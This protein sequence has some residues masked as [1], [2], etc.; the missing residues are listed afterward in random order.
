MIRL[1]AATAAL[2]LL[3]ACGDGQ[4]FEFGDP[5]GG[6]GT[7]EPPAAGTE[8]PTELAQ[9]LFAIT[10]N[11]DGAGGAGTL[12]VDLRSLD[13]SAFNAAYVR[14][15]SR[16]IDGYRAFEYREDANGNNRKFLAFV[17]ES[18]NGT[19]MAAAVA[20]GGQ[21]N[22]YFGGGFYAQN[23]AYSEPTGSAVPNSGVVRYSGS[24]A[25]II[26]IDTTG[27]VDYEGNNPPPS[28]NYPY[29]SSAVR[30]EALIIADFTNNTV[31][32]GIINR[33]IISE[34]GVT[35]LPESLDLVDLALTV[36]AI[37][38]NGEF[39][40]DVEPSGGTSSGST[41]GF[42]GG[43]FGGIGATDVAGVIL[44]NP[45]PSNSD[46]WE[47]GIF[48]FQTCTDVTCPEPNP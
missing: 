39:F 21:F 47:H 14:D 6:G 36:T 8:I 13:A 26:T 3:T 43:T 16:D 37:E 27:A 29:Q 35:V 11:P 44:I 42:Y 15:P 12:M 34:D 31:N 30:G 2:V 18:D 25:G 1:F 45:Y 5:D 7:P 28:G 46:I 24:Y 41:N 48:V 32:G 9:N 20:D 38:T 23:G 33:T 4:P 10:Y 22:R 40:G 19:V 17:R